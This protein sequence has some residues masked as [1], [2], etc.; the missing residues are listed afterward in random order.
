MFD[1]IDING[2]GECVLALIWKESMVGGQSVDINQ[3]HCRLQ[4]GNTSMITSETV[5][6]CFHTSFKLFR[7]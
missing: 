3:L 4:S 6:G 5:G 1:R 2:D 7:S